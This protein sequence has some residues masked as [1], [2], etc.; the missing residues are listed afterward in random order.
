MNTEKVQH[1]SATAEI[2]LVT[3]ATAVVATLVQKEDYD[4]GWS[5]V[6]FYSKTL[7]PGRSAITA[8]TIGNSW[9]RCKESR[10]SPIS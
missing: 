4:K 3:D 8:H 9:L 2:K 7:S 5:P 1:P 10:N 6:A